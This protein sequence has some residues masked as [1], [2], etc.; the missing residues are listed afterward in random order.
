MR[1]VNH[2]LGCPFSWSLGSVTGEGLGSVTGEGFF[3]CFLNAIVV[4]LG[5]TLGKV[6]LG[7]EGALSISA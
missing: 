5:L 7:A 6:D 1:M 3:N 2:V 4:T